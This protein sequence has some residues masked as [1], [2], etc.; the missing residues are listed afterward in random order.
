MKLLEVS[1]EK[2][3]ETKSLKII[4]IIKKMFKQRVIILINF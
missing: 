2:K 4:I 1:N 3:N